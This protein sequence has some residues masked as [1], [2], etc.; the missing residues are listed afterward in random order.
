MAWC[1]TFGVAV[2]D[3]NNKEPMLVVEGERYCRA[4]D[5]TLCGG[6]F[7][8]CENLVFAPGGIHLQKRSLPPGIDPEQPAATPAS[9]SLNGQTHGGD[10]VAAAGPDR[11]DLAE[12]IKRLQRIEERLSDIESQPRTQVRPQPRPQ[13]EGRRWF[14]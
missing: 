14:A 7:P 11:G 9:P 1:Y 8:G 12:I 2:G 4:A 10:N 3:P 5:G 13:P 6:R